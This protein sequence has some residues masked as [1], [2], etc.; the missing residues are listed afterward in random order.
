[1]Q[2]IFREQAHRCKPVIYFTCP[3]S[4]K[5]RP[6]SNSE[7]SERLIPFIIS[8]KVAV[9]NGN[10]GGNAESFVPYG[11][12]GSFFVQVKIVCGRKPW[13]HHRLQL[14]RQWRLCREFTFIPKNEITKE[15]QEMLRAVEEDCFGISPIIIQME[16]EEKGHLFGAVELGVLVLLDEGK[17]VGNAYLYKRLTDYAGQKYYIGGVGGLA[18]MPGYRGRGYAKQLVEKTLAM[19]YDIGVDVACLFTEREETVHKLYEKLGFSFL[20]R[21]GYYI[22]SLHKEAF[23]DDIMIMGLNNKELSEKILT[24]NHKFHYGEE[25]GCW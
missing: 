8:F 17:I 19:A 21:R 23:R 10:L 22:D 24:T 14:L 5:A 3:L 2:C 18:V 1:M 4:T 20:N 6:L 15:Q 16:T 12:K 11:V 13:K 7:R 25:E 9:T